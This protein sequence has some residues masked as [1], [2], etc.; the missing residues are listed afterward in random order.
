MWGIL[1]Q[2]IQLHWP[3]WA[4]GVVHMPVNPKCLLRQEGLELRASLGYMVNLMPPCAI[5]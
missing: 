3:M 4:A 5:E 2:R 1:L